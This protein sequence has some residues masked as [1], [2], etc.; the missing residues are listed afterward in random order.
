[1]A[2]PTAYNPKRLTDYFGKTD[3]FAPT[4]RSGTTS[5]P[6]RFVM[7]DR[8]AR[9][10]T[11][12]KVLASLRESQARHEKIMND[13]AAKKTASIERITKAYNESKKNDPKDAMGNTIESDVTKFLGQQLIQ[14][15]VGGGKVLG[16]PTPEQ[17]RKIQVEGAGGPGR[18]M[19]EGLPAP[20]AVPAAPAPAL[21]QP[22][23]TPIKGQ[24]VTHKSGTKIVQTGNERWKNN[25]R[26]IEAVVNGKKGW[27]P[28]KDLI[29]PETEDTG[30]SFLG[31]L[32]RYFQRYRPGQDIM[33]SV[34]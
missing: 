28:E 22:S 4:F 3:K 27:V 15:M 29:F 31:P 17:Q 30:E 12:N 18:G 16:V 8:G 9:G 13:L 7:A 6:G 11:S 21:K 33:E 20:P 26:E 23:R 24:E 32:G 2:V 10:D 5:G 19:F 14:G 25:Q 34:I 1:M